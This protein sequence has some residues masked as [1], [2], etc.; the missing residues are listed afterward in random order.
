M[1][2]KNV[3]QLQLNCQEIIVFPKD[4][5]KQFLSEQ[6]LTLHIQNHQE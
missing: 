2:N 5:N 4:V 3:K 6:L 1:F